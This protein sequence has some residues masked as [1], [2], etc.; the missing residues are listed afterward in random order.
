MSGFADGN[1]V[2]SLCPRNFLF[3]II[4]YRLQPINTLFGKHNVFRSVSLRLKGLSCFL[5]AR[6]HYMFEPEDAAIYRS[7][8]NVYEKC[9]CRVSVYSFLHPL[10]YPIFRGNLYIV[11]VAISCLAD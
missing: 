9:D 4:N 7:A 2:N 6:Y 3:L 11:V 10:C 5:L 1:V 8:I